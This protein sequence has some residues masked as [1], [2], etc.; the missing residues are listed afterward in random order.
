M[1]GFDALAEVLGGVLGGG[2]GGRLPDWI[3]PASTPNHRGLF[4]GMTAAAGVATVGLARLAELQA[5]CRRR[6]TLATQR[7]AS[8]SPECPV[9]QQAEWEARA[10]RFVAGLLTGLIAGYLSHLILDAATPKGLPV[11][12]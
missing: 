1:S 11:V 3:E 2:I 6:A 5:E 9:R 12:F 7:A 4:H 10:W 8:S